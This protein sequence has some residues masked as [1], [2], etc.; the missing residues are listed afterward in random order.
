MNQLLTRKI[1]LKLIFLIIEDAV[2]EC[3]SRHLI[4]VQIIF[5]LLYNLYKLQH[6]LEKLL[7]CNYVNLH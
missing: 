1:I 6:M 2:I 7:R 5:R 4:Y 3:I